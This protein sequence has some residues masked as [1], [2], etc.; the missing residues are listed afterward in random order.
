MA[1]AVVPD[2]HYGPSRC[3]GCHRAIVWALTE[4]GR[5]MPV[6]VE[7]VDGGEVELYAEYFP[8]GSPVDP[9]V[10]RVRARPADRPSSSPGWRCHFLTCSA[11]RGPQRI[12]QQI[13]DFIARARGIKWG[14]L[15][16][17]RG[18]QS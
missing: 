9:G 13:A 4:A 3:K 16:S 14:P 5:R 11:R 8:D 15:F 1:I 12:P 7:P 2:P 10:Q 18:G 17:S 6:D